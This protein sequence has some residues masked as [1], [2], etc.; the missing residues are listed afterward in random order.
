MESESSTEMKRS[1]MNS[2]DERL[3]DPSMEM[4]FDKDQLDALKADAESVTDDMDMKTIMTK[5]KQLEE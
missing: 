1:M 3:K 2:L 5:M 4:Y